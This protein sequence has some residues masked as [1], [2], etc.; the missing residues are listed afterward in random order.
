[1]HAFEFAQNAFSPGCTRCFEEQATTFGGRHVVQGA[2]VGKNGAA[3]VAA[4]ELMCG[5]NVTES[6]AVVEDVIPGRRRAVTLFG[7]VG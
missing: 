1:V 5:D 7:E 2:I 6:G 4:N 3:Q